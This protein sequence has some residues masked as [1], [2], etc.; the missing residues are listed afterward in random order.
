MKKTNN[1]ALIEKD[2]LENL[3]DTDFNNILKR[4]NEEK[5]KWNKS[6]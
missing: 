2:T 4:L 5:Q 3:I 6:S 1:E